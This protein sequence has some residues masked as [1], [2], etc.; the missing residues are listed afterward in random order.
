MKRIPLMTL[1]TAGSALCAAVA[2]ADV[3]AAVVEDVSGTPPGI[4]FMDYVSAGKVIRLGPRDTIVLG[5]LSSCWRET[6]T[7]GTVT[8]G[9]E[10][11]TVKNGKVERS[12]VQCGG[13][14][15]QMTS[16]KTFE[17]AGYVSRDVSGRPR[18]RPKTVLYSRLPIVELAGA[19]TLLIER[20]DGPSERYEFAVERRELVR[21]TFFDFARARQMLTAGAVYRATFGAKETVFRVDKAAVAAGP[22]VARLLRF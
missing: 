20:V 22:V 10:Q 9:T 6:I 16:E 12:L 11:S 5:Y 18:P 2:W 4:E 8:V 19:G 21:G 14:R 1:A 3:P 15:M 13:G 7:G 17:T